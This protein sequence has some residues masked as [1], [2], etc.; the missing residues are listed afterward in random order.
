MRIG[1]LLAWQ[2]SD[3]GRTHRSRANLLIHIV[4]VPAFLASNVGLV[5]A[6]ATGRWW[7]AAGCLLTLLVALALQGIGH[8]RESEVP[9][10]FTGRANF[11]IRMF[12]EQWFTFPRFV[13]SGGWARALRAT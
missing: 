10:P 2:W 7:T 6:L 1:D 4:A 8:R 3:Y 9:A 5:A 11:A 12:A 13:L